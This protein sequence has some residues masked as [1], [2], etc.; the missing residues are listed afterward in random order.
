MNKTIRF[1]DCTL[2]SPMRDD[3]V[4]GNKHSHGKRR[5][6]VVNGTRI[7]TVDIH[8]HCVVLA[9]LEVLNDK[10][11]NTALLMDDTS[12]RI[13]VMDAQGIDMSALSINPYWYHA[14]RDASVEIVRIQN[15]A[16]V[17][18]CATTPDRFTAF[19]TAAL[20]HPDL[21]VEQI[22]YAAKNSGEEKTG[23]ECG[24]RIRDQD[25]CNSMIS[26]S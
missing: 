21:A 11:G 24:D 23:K 6:V 4:A 26:T 9:A 17:E 5:E 8:A 7:K 13:A 15:E 20:Q 12:C 19:A 3:G 1:V 16:L 22:E 2:R 10:A 14:D 18:I 25:N